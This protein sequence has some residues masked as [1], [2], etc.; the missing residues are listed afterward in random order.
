LGQNQSANIMY[1]QAMDAVLPMV[2][3]IYNTL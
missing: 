3:T 1:R 2:L